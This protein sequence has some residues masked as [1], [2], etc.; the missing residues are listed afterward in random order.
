MSGAC[1]LEWGW[2]QEYQSFPNFGS[3]LQLDFRQCSRGLQKA[4]LLV[5]GLV[6]SLRRRESSSLYDMQSYNLRDTYTFILFHDKVAIQQKYNLLI[7]HI[8]Y[9]STWQSFI[10]CILT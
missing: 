1:L 10:G 6:R 3:E 9:F 8:I 5:L 2:G 4:L 7:T